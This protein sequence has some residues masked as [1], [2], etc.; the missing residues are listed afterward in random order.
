LCTATALWSSTA[1]SQT[2]DEKKPE[3]AKPAATTQPPA[4]KPADK[5]ATAAPPTA[6]TKPGANPAA[7]AGGMPPEMEAMMKAAQ[8]GEFHAKLKPLAGKWTVTSK[9]RMSPDQPWEE[10]TGKA[11]YK[12]G[13]GGRYLFQDVKA[14]PS[15][16]DKEQ[17]GPFEGF[18]MMGYDNMSKKYFSTWVDNMGT[19]LMTSTGTCDSSGKTF[20]F[21][22]DPYI[23]PMT[24]QNKTTK[25]ILK[26]AGDDKAVWEMYD[27]GPDGK[28]YMGL[29]VTYTRQK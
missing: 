10:S 3:A 28:E 16:K 4:A 1:Y 17:G 21:M 24:G 19:M 18:G 22:G 8:P 12:W 23:C 15:E 25:S 14:N 5:S 27:K 29:E 11:E 2:K 26:I 13:L 20:T 6:A 7:P 9:F